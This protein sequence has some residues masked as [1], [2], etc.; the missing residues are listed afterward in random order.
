[1]LAV[2]TVGTVSFSGPSPSS[3]FPLPVWAPESSAWRP[4]R[5]CVETSIECI[6]CRRRGCPSCCCGWYRDP[7]GSKNNAKTIFDREGGEGHTNTGLGAMEGC[8]AL[9][10]LHPHRVWHWHCQM[11]GWGVHPPAN[12]ARGPFSLSQGRSSRRGT[13]AGLCC[14]PKR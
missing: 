13:P 4:A 1:M 12:C 8:Q 14:S 2:G 3:P 11:C 5:M 10:F 7:K 9:D 6:E